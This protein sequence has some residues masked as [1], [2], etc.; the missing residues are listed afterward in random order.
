MQSIKQ[1]IP[2]CPVFEKK[3]TTFASPFENR[4]VLQLIM[5]APSGKRKPRGQQGRQ[6][7][8]H[9][10]MKL[11]INLEVSDLTKQATKELTDIIIAQFEQN[12][13]T[14]CESYAAGA[15]LKD[16]FTKAQAAVK[17][18]A[19][20]QAEEEHRQ[21]GCEGASVTINGLAFQVKHTPEYDF[22]H[23]A[24]WKKAKKNVVEKEA[25][26]KQA[27]V[28]LKSVEDRLAID[29]TPECITTSIAFVAK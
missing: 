5:Y 1:Y 16:A 28:E 8:N 27:K 4:V 11:N 14:A 24:E 29:M 25:R 13:L 15:I 7:P 10:I 26:L 17:T 20:E 23:K 12:G 21:Q 19:Q 2:D 18:R 3:S 9:E 6:L 22:T